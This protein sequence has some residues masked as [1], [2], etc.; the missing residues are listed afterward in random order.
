M[1]DISNYI[2][3]AISR[4]TDVMRLILSV[5][6]SRIVGV[7]FSVN[8]PFRELKNAVGMR[9][10]KPAV[11]S[12]PLPTSLTTSSNSCSDLLKPPAKKQ[13]PK[14]SSRLASIEP[15]MAALITGMRLLST[16]LWRRTM[17]RTIST[18]PPRKVSKSTPILKLVYL[19]GL[20]GAEF[21]HPRSQLYQKPLA[22]FV[23]AP[24]Q[25]SRSN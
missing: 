23:Q 15:S 1:R 6:S 17:K 13:H 18:I 7:K 5:L 9:S 14:H 11:N 22:A 4:M 19:A 8:E 21:K 2:K 25:R 3:Y 24:V 20:Q 16:L 10:P 12:R